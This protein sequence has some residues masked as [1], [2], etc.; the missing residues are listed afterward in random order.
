M[1]NNEKAITEYTRSELREF[2]ASVGKSGEDY[3]Q[4]VERLSA[5]PSEDLYK[6]LNKTQRAFCAALS[7]PDC[8]IKDAARAAGLSDSSDAVL[9][10]AGSRMLRNVKVAA[11]RRACA[12]DDCRALALTRENCLLRLNSIAVRARRKDD[13]K[14]ELAALKTMIQVSGV[15]DIENDGTDITVAISLPGEAQEFAK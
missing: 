6:L 4:A 5:L 8:T 9:S 13:L 10:S 11:Y 12:R 7:E 2:I 15:C 3:E 14:N 1:S